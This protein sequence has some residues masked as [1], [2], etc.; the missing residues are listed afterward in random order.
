MENK[1]SIYDKISPLMA[2]IIEICKREGIPMFA[3][4]EYNTGDFCRTLIRPEGCHM[5]N[6]LFEALGRCAQEEGVNIDSFMIHL[7]RNYPNKSSAIL[8]SL[9]VPMG[10]PV[11]YTDKTDCVWCGQEITYND[12]DLYKDGSGRAY[13]ECSNCLKEV[14]IH[15]KL[16]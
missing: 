9:G 8:H 4:F 2:K 15:P 1:E 11:T 3:S 14:I 7:A 12:Q 10:P 13:L 16:T 6:G 5:V